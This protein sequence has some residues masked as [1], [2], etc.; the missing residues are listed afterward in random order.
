MLGAS[1]FS[2]SSQV[3]ASLAFTTSYTPP[4]SN[5]VSSLFPK[6]LLLLPSGHWASVSLQ[7]PLSSHSPSCSSPCHVRFQSYAHMSGSIRLVPTSSLVTVRCNTCSKHSDG[8]LQ[9]SC[10]PLLLLKGRTGV[11]SWLALTA[12]LMRLQTRASLS[13][14]LL[15]A[16]LL[17]KTLS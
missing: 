12:G 14:S 13:C 1:L 8:D 5:R 6:I 7:V 3:A 16:T 17:W 15:K 4:V 10:T 11:F 2:R 9:S